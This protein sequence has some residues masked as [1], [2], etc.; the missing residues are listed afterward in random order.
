MALKLPMICHF[1]KK[2]KMGYARK[3]S[4]AEKFL[5][6]H[7][8]LS[9]LPFYPFL[10]KCYLLAHYTTLI[11]QFSFI[12]QFFSFFQKWHFWPKNAKNSQNAIFKGLGSKISN[13]A[14]F[15]SIRLRAVFSYRTAG[16]PSFQAARSANR[17]HTSTQIY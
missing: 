13:A 4:E 8:F 17:I 11:K 10:R 7:F 2:A 1:S 6:N 12:F 9:D 14:N 5:K 15:V 3:F 16:K